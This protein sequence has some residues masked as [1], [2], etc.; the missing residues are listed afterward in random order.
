MELAAATKSYQTPRPAGELVAK[1]AAVE[2]LSSKVVLT[3][4][5]VV[6]DL[7]GSET[8]VK[9]SF[10]VVMVPHLAV[11]EVESECLMSFIFVMPSNPQIIRSTR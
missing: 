9:Q 3:E 11:I 1:S 8:G 2:A 6:V 5:V 4:V 10:A 7:P